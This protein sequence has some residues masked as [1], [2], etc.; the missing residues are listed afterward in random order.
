MCLQHGTDHLDEIRE[1]LTSNL[2][3]EGIHLEPIVWARLLHKLVP[4]GPDDRDM[5]QYFFKTISLRYWE[6][7][8]VV[9]PPVYE[10]ED[11]KIIENANSDPDRL[12]TTFCLY[13]YPWVE[14]S[15]IQ[16]QLNVT[17][18]IFNPEI[19]D[20][21]P[22]PQDPRLRFLLTMI[23]SPSIQRAGIDDPSRNI[24][25]KAISGIET[26]FGLDPI[27]RGFR[28]LVPITDFTHHRHAV[29]KILYTLLSS[30]YFGKRE[31]PIEH[32]RAAL[33]L[34]LRMVEFTSPLPPFMSRDWCTPDL[35]AEFVRIAFEH[36]AWAPIHIFDRHPDLVY[37]LIKCLVIHFPLIV[38]EAFEYATAKRLFD[39]L[40]EKLHYSYHNLFNS[41]HSVPLVLKMF[42]TGLPSSKLE[43]QIS[44]NFLRYLHEPDVLF[45]ICAFLV[46]G[47]SSEAL[48]DLARLCP[49]DPAWPDCLQ[50]LREYEYR[51][52]GRPAR[53]D[54][55]GILADL[56]A[57][58]E[59]GGVDRMSNTQRSTIAG[60][61]RIATLSACL[62]SQLSLIDIRRRNSNNNYN[63]SHSRASDDSEEDDHST[64]SR[65]SKGTNDE[66]VVRVF[67]LDSDW[68]IFFRV[69]VVLVLIRSRI[70]ELSVSNVYPVFSGASSNWPSSTLRQA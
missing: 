53:H 36:G 22:S 1:F 42:I 60:K 35:A 38:N 63:D 33:V 8:F 49:N 28:P 43:S 61:F 65:V 30:D 58:L 41:Y 57:F 9:P 4:F 10:W 70:D 27:K 23:G 69:I 48:H 55:P 17:D 13:L 21:Y 66:H 39:R 16:G 52:A 37:K 3:G 44:Q 12:E 24:F 2:S 54:I 15:I 47:G 62:G 45:A 50:R 34:F 67:V 18:S 5:A 64:F 29:L 19:P 40:V 14:E 25:C 56:T 46:G 11:I 32:Q 7:N 26:F 6:A 51:P 31:V 68:I 20:D 59:G